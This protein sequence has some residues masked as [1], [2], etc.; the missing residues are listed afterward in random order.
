MGLGYQVT[1]EDI[2]AILRRHAV[3][4]ANSGGVSF[5]A[6]GEQLLAAG[7][8]DEDLVEQVALAACADEDDEVRLT[9]QTKAASVEIVRQ[10]CESGVFEHDITDLETQFQSSTLF[11]SADAEA[12]LLFSGICCGPAALNGFWSKTNGWGSV[13]FATPFVRGVEVSDAEAMQALI[14]VDDAVFVPTDVAAKLAKAVGVIGAGVNPE[15]DDVSISNGHGQEGE[16]VVRS[17]ANGAGTEMVARW[18]LDQITV[19]AFEM[20]EKGERAEL[21]GFKWKSEYCGGSPGDYLLEAFEEQELAE[22]ATQL[23]SEQ[24]LL[25]AR[26]EMGAGVV[27]KSFSVLFVAEETG[28]IGMRHAQASDGYAAIAAVA[29][30]MPGV[31]FVA[32]V[33]GKLTEESGL[34]FPGESLVSSATVLEQPEVFGDPLQGVVDPVRDASS[35]LEV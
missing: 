20:N 13:Q 2:T 18:S 21:S 25:A 28:K 8:V 22:W 24:L 23:A 29:K 15:V 1:E 35:S 31:E 4:V 19:T 17:P 32:A 9:E 27:L 5:A 7:F 14:S 26:K 3:H 34:V 6:M 30:V 12:M 16:L 33:P 10:L 11:P